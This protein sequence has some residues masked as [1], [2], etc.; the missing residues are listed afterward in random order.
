M[1]NMSFD[2]SKVNC[3]LR[4]LISNQWLAIFLE[5]TPFFP[6]FLFLINCYYAANLSCLLIISCEKNYLVGL[7]SLIQD[8]LFMRNVATIKPQEKLVQSILFWM[9]VDIWISYE[10]NISGLYGSWTHHLCDTGVP[11]GSSSFCWFVFNPW[12]DAHNCFSIRPVV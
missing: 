4:G 7:Y 6:S 3:W 12:S 5:K 10:K 9:T 1:Y 8:F 11:T 2:S